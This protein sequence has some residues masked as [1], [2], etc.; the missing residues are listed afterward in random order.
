MKELLEAVAGRL[1]QET[2]VRDVFVTT[3]EQTLLAGTR[4]P[5]LAVKDGKVTT[6]KLAGGVVEKSMQ[7][8][9]IAWAPQ[10]KDAAQVMGDA[11]QPGVLD[12]AAAAEG[13]LD[14]ELLGID[15]MI[16]AQPVEELASVL[17]INQQGKAIQ[18]KIITFEY[19]RQR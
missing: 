15:G 10:G 9:V 16:D 14:G 18:Q 3:D 12:L 7:V 8:R 1:R 17:Y 11:T 2:G 4:L 19:V 13:A 5:A 6:R